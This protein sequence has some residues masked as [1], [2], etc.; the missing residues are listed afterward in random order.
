MPVTRKKAR[1]AVA[2]SVLVLGG[3]GGAGTAAAQPTAN[4]PV[5]HSD[6]DTTASTPPVKALPPIP[7]GDITVRASC[8][9]FSG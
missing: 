4:G 1:M 2:A 7:A 5:Q 6:C 3:A 8:T 9:N